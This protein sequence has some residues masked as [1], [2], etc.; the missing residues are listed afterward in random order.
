[1]YIHTH[2][3]TVYIMQYNTFKWVFCILHVTV[4]RL[5]NTLID[6]EPKSQKVYLLT[7]LDKSTD[8]CLMLS[9]CGYIYSFNSI[10]LAN[11]H[12]D[13]LLSNI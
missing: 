10:F 13:F 4:Y 6:S 11:Y 9:R 5:I 8:H 1:M 7:V 2:T 12:Q 3:Y